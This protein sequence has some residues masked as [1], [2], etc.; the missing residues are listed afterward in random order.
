MSQEWAP[1]TW[2]R[3]LG[4]GWV[5]SPGHWYAIRW[6]AA[7]SLPRPSVWSPPTSYFVTAS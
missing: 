2:T 4:L 6:N 1:C 5:E 3:Y 7:N